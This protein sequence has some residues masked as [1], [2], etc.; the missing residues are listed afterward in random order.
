MKDFWNF[1]LHNCILLFHAEQV[2]LKLQVINLKNKEVTL[3]NWVF[4][5]PMSQL[6]T[7]Y[8]KP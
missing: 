4:K 5:N 6:E 7:I 8:P 3:E 2:Y 1:I